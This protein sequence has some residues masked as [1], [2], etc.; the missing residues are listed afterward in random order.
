MISALIFDFDGLILETEGP[1][2][3]SWKE[4]Y[5]AFGQELSFSA[6]AQSIGASLAEFDPRLDLQARLGR[7]INWEA[8][9]PKR[10]AREVSLIEQQSVLPG[11]LAYLNTARCLGI[12]LGLASSSSCQWVM[13]HLARLRLVEY[14]D[15]IRASDDV[16]RVKPDP[17]LYLAVL[18]ALMVRAAEAIAIED[19][20]NGI[21][22]AKRAGLY[23]V[24]VPN[25]LTKQLPLNQADLQ[26]HSLE[27]LPLERLLEQVQSS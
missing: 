6:W 2:F 8:I 1:I 15:C 13:G 16:K 14:F 24:A 19:S 17:E 3:Q 26:L 22:S 5:H 27:D 9:E 7:Q 25:L 23:C 4:V 18:D 21:L 10:M 11:V 20:P 12:K